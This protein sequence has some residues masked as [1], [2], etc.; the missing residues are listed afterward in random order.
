MKAVQSIVEPMFPPVIITIET[1]AELTHLWCLLNQSELQ[2][3]ELYKHA[4]LVR[5]VANNQQMFE[6]LDAIFR[7]DVYKARH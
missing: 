7:P 3:R 5:P 4:P 2:L 1:Q 6:T